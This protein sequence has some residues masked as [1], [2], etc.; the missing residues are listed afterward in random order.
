MTTFTVIID[1]SA[2][3]YESLL[4]AIKEHNTRRPE[5]Q[6]T[7]DGTECKWYLPRTIATDLLIELSAKRYVSLVEMK[8]KYD[9]KEDTLLA[10]EGG[11]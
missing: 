5:I 7:P 11:Q 3:D 6:E 9:R 1:Y 8:I 10:E 4:T 2:S